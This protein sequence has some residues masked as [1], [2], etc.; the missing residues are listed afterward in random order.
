[1]TP[2][3]H[4]STQARGAVL[5]QL[6]AVRPY[7]TSRP[8]RI[9]DLTLAPPGPGEILVRIEAA[10]VCH[11]DLSVINGDRPRPVP[12]VLG[13]EAAGIIE[14]LGDEVG[15]LEVGDRVVMTFLP[16]CGHC[17]GCRS[18]G[19]IPCSEGSATNSSGHLLGGHTRISD[20]A[21]EPVLHHLG[22]SAFATHAVVSRRSVVR[23][24]PD[25]PAEVAA[26][27]GCALLTGGGAVINVVRP[28]PET[29]V[30][31]VGLGG[32]GMA[33]LITAKALGVT[34]L[35]GID[36]QADKLE[37]AAC[38]G[39]TETYTPSEALDRGI[40]ADAVVEAAGNIRAF[41]TAVRVTGVGGTTVTVGLPAPGQSATIDP[42]TLTAQAR[43]IVGSYLGSS[44]PETD[45]KLYEHM[46]REGRLDVRDL[47]SATISLENINEAMDDLDAGRTLR[48]II[49]F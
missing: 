15:D 5:T 9:R 29:S 3:N 35:I 42:L 31:V 18:F 26:V 16:R 43:T 34:R 28:R 49:A 22:V 41:E 40:L 14:T 17:A 25:V 19:R 36:T 11:S 46:W 27:F 47:I 24:G 1:M 6:G 2:T 45:I 7:A 23:V 12:M 37:I 8:L 21:D 38:L 44:V 48:Q 32:V 4:Q 13:H 30:A 20:T 39:A 33:A 10:G